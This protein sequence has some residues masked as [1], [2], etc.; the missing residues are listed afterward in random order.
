MKWILNLLF[1]IVD[2]WPVLKD[3]PKIKEEWEELKKKGEANGKVSTDK[4]D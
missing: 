3:D 4:Y 1:W 2:R